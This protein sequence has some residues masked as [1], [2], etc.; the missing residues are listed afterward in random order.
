MS[1]GWTLV[2]VAS[3]QVSAGGVGGVV[4][5][6]ATMKFADCA[7]EANPVDTYIATGGR[8]KLVK[9]WDVRTGQCVQTLVRFI[10]F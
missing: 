5:R 2:V 7:S 1:T 4:R 3:S 8:D 9:L 10:F 6:L